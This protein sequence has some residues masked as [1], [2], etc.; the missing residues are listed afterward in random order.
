MKVNILLT[1][2][3]VD[4]QSMPEG[5]VM[6]LVEEFENGDLAVLRFSL[7]GESTTHIAR[8]HIVRI[9]IVPEESL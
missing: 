9:D 8:E 7:D 5:D 1:R 2:G 3:H 6:D 4:F